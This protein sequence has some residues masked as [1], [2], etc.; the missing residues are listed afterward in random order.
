MPLLKRAPNTVAYSFLLVDDNA[1]NLRILERVLNRMYPN[2]HITKIQDLTKVQPVI[3]HQ[4]FDMVFLDIEMPCITGVDLARHMRSQR[5]YDSWG[6]VAV[7]TRNTA[8][9]V[10]IYKSA[11]IDFTFPKPLATTHDHM[12]DTINYILRARKA[13][14]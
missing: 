1:I 8:S 12:M 5:K 2:S 14:Y 6:I 7:T 3:A 10:A 4:A 11:G 13:H 9:D